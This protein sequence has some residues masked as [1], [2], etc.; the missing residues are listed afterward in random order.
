[1]STGTS[2]V[3]TMLLAGGVCSAGLAAPA[4]LRAQ[5]KL[6]LTPFFTSYYPLA[7]LTDDFVAS[8]FGPG[9]SVKQLSTAGFG[10]RLTYWV[11]RTL[12]IE[13]EGSYIPSVPRIFSEKDS[14]NVASTL[15]GSIVTGSARLLYRPSRTNLFLLGGLGIV[16]R[17]GDTWQDI[18][19]PTAF[20]GVLGFGVRASVT[21]KLALYVSAEAFLYSTDPDGPDF[22]DFPE[23]KFQ[24][25]ILVSIGV[26]ITLM[27]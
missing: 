15:S 9:V 14:V 6:E 12:G 4:A 26:P 23:S 24:Q 10:G 8:F 5:A 18:D 13:A 3:R 17:G 22:D 7:T 11:S 2:L 1:V 19:Q 21:P 16:N 20:G 27:R 25:D